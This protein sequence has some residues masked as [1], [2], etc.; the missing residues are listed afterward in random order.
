MANTDK[1]F[2]QGTQLA[3]GG[4]TI[5]ELT[6]IGLP[7]F[8]AD[9]IDVTTHNSSDYVREFVKGL[10]D[11]G[12]VPFEGVFN[13]TDYSELYALQFT[14]SLQSCTIAIP[15]TP[16]ETQVLINGYVKSVNGTVP[17]DEKAE[18]GGSLKIAN[19]PTMQQV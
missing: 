1:L 16:S 18:I 7:E 10:T 6:S 13:Y 11:A 17:H 3:I 19:K 12:E 15:T 8:E 9:D 5:S 4:T 2:A 14:Q